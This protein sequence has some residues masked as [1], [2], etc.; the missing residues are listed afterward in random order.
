MLK[1]DLKKKRKRNE[2]ETNR[3]IENQ[4]TFYRSSFFCFCSKMIFHLLM[5]GG[6]TTEWKIS[7]Q[8]ADIYKMDTSWEVSLVRC[9][10]V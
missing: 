1:F 4:Y 10:S 9:I 8:F 5:A 2:K 7:M 3:K 6:I